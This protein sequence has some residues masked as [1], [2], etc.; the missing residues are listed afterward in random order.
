MKLTYNRFTVQVD[1]TDDDP[2]VFWDSE[3]GSGESRLLYHV[4]R[5]LLRDGY[6]VIKKRKY[7]DG[8]YT[9]GKT[10][11]TQ[12]Y[13]R[14]RLRK[15]YLHAGTSPHANL[16][17]L[18]NCSGRIILHAEGN[19]P[20]LSQPDPAYPRWV[21]TIVQYRG[22]G[23]DGCF[24]EWNYAYFDKRGVFY[25]LFHSGRDGCPTSQD[26]AEL[27]AAYADRTDHVY[28]YDLRRETILP[29][30]GEPEL[31]GWHT[32]AQECNPEQVIHVGEWFR[33]Y[34]KR[35]YLTTCDE[36][37]NSFAAADLHP[38]GAKGNG[39]IGIEFTSK[40]CQS[41]IDDEEARDEEAR[42]EAEREEAE[43][44]AMPTFLTDGK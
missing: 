38:D 6:D 5:A 20:W 8:H 16:A 32:F 11:D 21:D 10:R 44:G 13:I 26:L 30:C 41:C 34:V 15:W 42:E 28:T 33:R 25:S 39:G 22:G 19:I 43:A 31:G 2:R 18:F 14:D 29:A 9:D 36:C 12:Q 40:R 24:W 37:G 3:R 17:D 23:Y 27:Y 35:D 4:K 7:R 1:R